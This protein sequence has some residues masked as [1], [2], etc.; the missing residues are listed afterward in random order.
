MSSLGSVLSIAQSGLQVAQTGLDVV[1]NN[2]ANV[3]TPGYVRELV[4]QSSVTANGTGLGVTVDGI[5]RATNSYLE[6][7]NLSAQSDAGSASITSSI[8]TQA[9]SL[10]GDPTSSS[11][12][13]GQLDSVFSAFSSLAA[14][15]NSS[16][17][18]AA[19]TQTSQFFSSASNVSAGLRSLSGQADQQISSDVSTVNQLL[20]QISA[21]NTTI[22]QATISGEDASGA[23]N[24]Q[25]SLVG[26]LSKLMNVTSVASST[27]AVTLRAG[28]GTVLADG[29]GAATLA[30]STSGSGGQLSITPFNST[31]AQSADGA[32]TSGEISGLVGLRNVQLPGV[33][34]QV[35]QLVTQTAKQLNAAA[36][37]NASVPAPATLTGAPT[38]MSLANDINNFSGTTSIAIV[39]SA[40]VVQ[41]QVQVAFNGSGGTMT[42]AGG[43]PVAFTSA[44]FATAL[45]SALGPANASVGFSAPGGALSISALGAGDG[46]VISDSAVNP[47][48]KAGSSFS[49]FFG[50]NNLV[51]TPSPTNYDTG[52]TG[53]D[54]S[55]FAPGQTISFR[56]SAADGSTLKTVTATTP[57]GG[58]MSDLVAALNN[59][60]AGVGAY[61]A[62]TLAGGTGELSFQPTAGSGVGLS[63]ASDQTS[64][65]SGV[66]LSALFGIGDA[67]RTAAADGYAV[68][69]DIVADAAKLQTSAVDLTGG[70]GSV[71][72]SPGSNSGADALSQAGRTSVGFDAVGGLGAMT[73]SVSN[74]ASALSGALAGSS[75]AASTASTDASAVSTEAQTRLS[76]SEGVNIDQELVSLTTYQQAYNASARLIQAAKDMFDTLLSM[77]GT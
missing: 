75:T 9:Q 43:Q 60:A 72:T 4:N 10:F 25:S 11:S 55:D 42:A 28:D 44:N 68:R 74:Y 1:S 16:A 37:A 77:A 13:F 59:S 17:E 69:P 15:P 51:Q 45:T 56:L 7:A 23:Q 50:L 40:G 70:V 27:G 47:S 31:T 12:L 39:D 36:N 29:R 34:G 30:Y 71:A 53:S 22:S 35:A 33:A 63:V 46:V 20:S 76:S 5:T 58:T 18:T 67:T 8:L 64:N 48:S 24:Q 21:L 26:Q 52:L 2:V 65:I 62:F 41:N 57:P 73:V 54:A 66:S 3:N 49:A 61:G 6:A 38:G 14:T 19:V 32:I